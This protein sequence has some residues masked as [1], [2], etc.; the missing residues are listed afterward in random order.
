MSEVYRSL[1]IELPRN[2]SDQGKSPALQRVDFERTD[3]AE[4]RRAAVESLQVGDLIYIP[5]HVMMMIGRLD[6]KP[7]VIH[8]TNG[9]SF[10]GP[11]GKV[12]SMH[13]NAVSVTPLLPLRF[14]TDSTYVDRMTHIVRIRP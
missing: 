2:T 1:G 12:R 14:S 3:S 9:G 5:G 10:L 13:L 6:G 11:D 8:D 4:R 7:Y